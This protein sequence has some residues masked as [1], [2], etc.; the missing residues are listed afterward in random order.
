MFSRSRSEPLRCKV[1]WLSRLN[2]GSGRDCGLCSATARPVF[3]SRSS[4]WANCFSCPASCSKG[5][6]GVSRAV[7]AISCTWMA[8]ALRR[9]LSSDKSNADLLKLRLR[10]S[11]SAVSLPNQE[12]MLWLINCADTP[13]KNRPGN[14]ATSV[15][16]I[17]KRRAIC[18]PNSCRRLLRTNCHTYLPTMPSKASSSRLLKPNTHQK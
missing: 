2:W 5:A 13:N 8:V 4:S 18:E 7:A 12:S 1:A 6:G 17:A 10:L 14:T 3:K 15:N 9:L 16:I 11:A